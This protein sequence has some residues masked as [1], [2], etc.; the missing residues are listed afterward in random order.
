[1]SGVHFIF[2]IEDFLHYDDRITSQ[3]PQV[4]AAQSASAFVRVPFSLNPCPQATDIKAHA[5]FKGLKWDQML[6][7][8]IPPPFVP[9]VEGPCSLKYVRPKY[10]EQVSINCDVRIIFITEKYP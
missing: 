7:L 2:G 1:M 4:P 8:A 6:A 5:F 9:D 3:G 10:L